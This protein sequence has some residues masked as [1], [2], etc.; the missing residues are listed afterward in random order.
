MGY[1]FLLCSYC[2]CWRSVCRWP[3]WPV[4]LLQRARWW[5][6]RRP[7]GHLWSGWA[8]TS[9]CDCAHSHSH[10]PGTSWKCS[11]TL[12]TERWEMM[13]MMNVNSTLID[14]N[15]VCRS[16]SGHLMHWCLHCYLKCFLK[17]RGVSGASISII[18]PVQSCILFY[19]YLS[20]RE[21]T[22][23]QSSFP[24]SNCMLLTRG[25]AILLQIN[26]GWKQ[27]TWISLTFSTMS[28]VSGQ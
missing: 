26:A 9:C 5:R 17:A 23:L 27:N 2:G 18:I 7:P 11:P 19:Y 28:S 12:H 13:M 25:G 4:R 15:Q 1:L 10:S 6:G 22:E 24:T 8:Q 16:V 14:V 20:L 3:L 21:E